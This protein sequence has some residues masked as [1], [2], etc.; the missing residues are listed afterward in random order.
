MDTLGD[1][2]ADVVQ[3][4]D[5]HVE[6]WPVH[7]HSWNYVA[8]AAELPENGSFKRSWV[9]DAPVVVARDRDGA[10]HCVV[11]RCAHR[12]VEFVRELR[13]TL[14]CIRCPYRQWTYALDGRLTGV[15]FWHGVGGKGGMPSDFEPS[16]SGLQQ[17]SV[18]ERNG[19][20]FA[21]FAGEPHSLERSLGSM[22]RSLS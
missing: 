9:G 17:L 7:S 6:S 18:A 2:L 4:V 1:S 5:V 13:G 11:N 10:V 8:L 15:P 20:I 3:Y 14:K 21:S 19:V 12:G 16:A 22:P